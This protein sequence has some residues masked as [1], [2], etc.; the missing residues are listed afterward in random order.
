LKIPSFMSL[1][2][3]GFRSEIYNLKSAVS[4]EPRIPLTQ[5]PLRSTLLRTAIF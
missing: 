1:K 4:R 2:E 3:F 5:L